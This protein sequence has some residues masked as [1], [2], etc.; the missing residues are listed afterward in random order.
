MVAHDTPTDEIAQRLAGRRVALV[1]DYLVTLRGGERILLAL[2]RLFPTADCYALLARR[3]GLPAELAALHARTTPLQWIPGAAR[4]Y[5]ALLPLYPVAARALDLRGYDLVISDSSGFCHGVRTDGPHLCYC[6][7][8]LRYAWHEYDAT[9]AAQRSPLRRAVL[10]AVLG[11]V[12][13]ADLAAARRVTAYAANSAAVR[14]RIQQYYGR[15][16][17]IVHP[18]VDTARFQPT[19]EHDDYLLAVAQLHAYK[20]VGLVVEACTRLGRRLVVVGEGPERARLECLAG[21]SVTFLPRV[22]EAR[23]AALYAGCAALV[24]CGLEDFGIAALEA[25]ASGRPVLAFGA[26]GA[27]ETVAEGTTGLFFSV[28]TVAAVA[29]AIARCDATAFDPAAIRAHAERF[30]ESRFRAAL[31]AVVVPLLAPRTSAL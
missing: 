9:L 1:H 4:H 10:R 24:Q 8:P 27:L 21:P 31:L 26:G 6:H 7:T 14:A 12:R 17:T 22:D 30:E 25:Q 18:F 3:H 15:D 16:S 5:R 13:R 19:P 11:G 28:Q 23:L 20:Q 29:D 2:K